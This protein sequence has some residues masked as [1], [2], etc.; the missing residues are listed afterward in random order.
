MEPVQV[1]DP[2]IRESQEGDVKSLIID[3]DEEGRCPTGYYC[4]AQ[5][6]CRRGGASASGTVSASP[7]DVWINTNA[8]SIGSTQICWQVYQATVGE[9]WVSVDGQPELLFTQAQSGC[10]FAWWIQVGHH[11][12]FRLYANT[13][14]SQLLSTVTVTGYGYQGLR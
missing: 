2:G 10:E 1:S 5:W 8:T 11:Y 4:D 14:H 13:T 6:L 7:T 3:C 12:D 9:V